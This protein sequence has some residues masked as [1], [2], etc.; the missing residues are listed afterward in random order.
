M[1]VT[2]F[3][4]I[5]LSLGQTDAKGQKLALR[6]S[7]KNFGWHFMIWTTDT[8]KCSPTKKPPLMFDQNNVVYVHIAFQNQEG[9]KIVNERDEDIS[10]QMREVMGSSHA[11]RFYRPTDD[12]IKNHPTFDEY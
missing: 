11:L 7:D 5:F 8:M 6:T 12:E 4:L 2:L 9:A 10:E 1:R 3:L